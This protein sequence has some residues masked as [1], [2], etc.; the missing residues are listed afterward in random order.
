MS[1]H[2]QGPEFGYNGYL[3]FNEF[4]EVN[5]APDSVFSDGARTA[6]QRLLREHEAVTE[7]DRTS[8][9]RVES[10][11]DLVDQEGE[12][13][14]Y[15]GESISNEQLLP[16]RLFFEERVSTE[17]YLPGEAYL[18]EIEL[19]VVNDADIYWVYP[20]R[21]YIRGSEEDADEAADFLTERMNARVE[22][23]RQADSQDTQN[24]EPQ[25][26]GGT[27]SDTNHISLIDVSFGAHFLIWLFQSHFTSRSL[28]AWC[29]IQVNRL[30]DARITGNTDIWGGSN[31]IGDSTDLIESPPL[32][33]AIL[34]N[35][36]FEM[37]EGN[38]TINGFSVKSE[39]NINKIH[40]K[41]STSDVRNANKRKRMAYSLLFLQELM[42]LHQYWINL[43]PQNKYPDYG[44]LYD[45]FHRCDDNG[46]TV[47]HIS[48]T[49]RRT[50]RDL[51]GE[52]DAEWHL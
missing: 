16:L 30:T 5:L 34:K 42:D 31:S 48:R 39:I 2:P 15:T 19:P 38:F 9:H 51:R 43:N 3:M 13:E 10:I 27:Q 14:F 7:S 22:Q 46:L 37:L 33:S 41:A 6:Q 47:D 52:S 44:F 20:D 23:Q 32:L 12:F 1:E 40:I 18:R 24:N 21:L 49:L 35:K 50:Y 26:D 36:R 45:L 29:E 11:D 17:G 25:T 8:S 28:P 4:F